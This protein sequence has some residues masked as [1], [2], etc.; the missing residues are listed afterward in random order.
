MRFGIVLGA[1]F[2]LAF[3][4]GP[5]V[6]V[7]HAARLTLL[8]A[9]EHARER[10]PEL[11]AARARL[12]AVD[13]ARRQASLFFQ[14]NP[15]LGFDGAHGGP[16]GN[17]GER[18]YALT[19][20]QELEV[21]G[22]PMLRGEVA[23]LDY[24]AARAR[25]AADERAYAARVAAAFFDSLASRHRT[26]L[27]RDVR[28]LNVELFS[29]SERRLRAGDVAEV[30][31][32]LILIERDRARAEARA[33][34]AAQEVAD[35]EL[36][37]LLGNPADAAVEAE[38]ALPDPT[39]FTDHSAGSARMDVQAARLARLARAEEAA[40]AA[41]E[42]FPNPTLSLGWERTVSTVG[43]DDF[44]GDRDLAATLGGFVDTD[45]VILFRVSLPLPLFNR[46]Q[47]RIEEAKAKFLAA[48]YEAVAVE[49]TVSAEAASALA[50]LRASS[51]AVSLFG[52]TL[53][54]A[55][56]NLALLVKAFK[57][58]QIDATTL[59]A[60]RD[61]AFRARLDYLNARRDYAMALVDLI[62]ARGEDPATALE[63]PK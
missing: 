29:V 20:S 9:L 48:R 2:V 49:R 37:R 21:A 22:Q 35:A 34:E 3:V 14:N 56:R 30:E 1:C 8:E 60:A 7:A 43:P 39:R 45:D 11:Q 40:L 54:I 15:E 47:G 13:G 26:R 63:E 4:G 38:G 25:L 24:R 10:A 50:T 28:D 33:A 6:P 41:R 31:H 61:R 19:V 44:G 51:A 36:N 62:R 12:S 53:P 18:S 59:L 5:Q 17:P 27:L 16:F 58:G 57:A 52:D 23:D 46:S 42:V 55:E 32:N